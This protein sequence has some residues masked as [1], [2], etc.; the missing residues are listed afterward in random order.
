METRKK[1]IIQQKIVALQ[2]ERQRPR[3]RIG[4]ICWQS[5]QITKARTGPPGWRYRAHGLG[6]PDKGLTLI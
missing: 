5:R 6:N 3:L 4:W 1:V 2:H